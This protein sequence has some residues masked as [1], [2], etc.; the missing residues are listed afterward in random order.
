LGLAIAGVSALARLRYKMHRRKLLAATTLGICL[1]GLN[2]V[3]GAALWPVMHEAVITHA[4]PVRVSPVPIEEPI[5][6]LPEA[7][8]V[9]MTD[10]HDGFVLVRASSGRT[11]WV[12]GADLVSIVPKH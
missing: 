3:N 12:P 9:R 1:L 2:L 5:F 8:V 6:V 10:E 7:S 4:A 11:G